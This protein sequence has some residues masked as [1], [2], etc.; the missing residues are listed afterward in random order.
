MRTL[1]IVDD[2]VM[3]ADGLHAMLTEAFAGRLRVLR[4]YSAAQAMEIAG[5]EAV[6]ILLTDI[7]M[8]DASGLELHQALAEKQPDCRVI[9]LTGYS[10]F[11][12][13][14]KALDQH[15]FAYVLKGEGDDFVISTVERAMADAAG[16]EEP[17]PEEIGADWMPRLHEYIRAHLNE[18]LSLNR[19]ADFCHFHPVYL[20][21]VYK[22]TTGETLSDFINQARQEQA[23]HLLRNTRMTVLEISRLMGFAT[24][25]YFCRWFR[26]RVGVS[27]HA[28]RAGA[29]PTASPSSAR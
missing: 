20:S 4:C 21:R 24:D 27:P 3:I 15:A 11:E 12:Y 6:H 22:E 23:K 14:R 19:L 16:P 26:K 8:P 2:E 9:Y 5:R 7:N 1:L 10:D 25:N 28:Y 29:K 18:D 13:A 17:V